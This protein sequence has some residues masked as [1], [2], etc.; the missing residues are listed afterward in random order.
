MNSDV[1]INSAHALFSALSAA[2]RHELRT[3]QF[4]WQV[5]VETKQF[6][7]LLLFDVSTCSKPCGGI[8]GA[9]G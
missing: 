5:L 4:A 1:D 9:R 6:L 8:F 3:P 2:T 7:L